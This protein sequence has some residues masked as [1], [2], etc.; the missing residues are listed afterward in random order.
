[1]TTETR[2]MWLIDTARPYKLARLAVVSI[3]ITKEQVWCDTGRRS[4]LYGTSAFGTL[5][6]AHRECYLRMT[7]FV[8]NYHNQRFAP[9]GFA[10]CEAMLSARKRVK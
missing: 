5:D 3:R 7:A 2:C 1:M 8:S 6:A 4:Y 9:N 10:L